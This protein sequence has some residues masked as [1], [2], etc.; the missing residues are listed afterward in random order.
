MT[1]CYRMT[2]QAAADERVKK[3]Y[4]FKAV[5]YGK[6]SVAADEHCAEA[7]K[8]YAISLG[9]IGDFLGV[10]EKIRNGVSF[11]AHIDKAMKINPTDALLHHLLGRFTYEVLGAIAR[12]LSAKVSG[13]IA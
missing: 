7:H 3:E 4:S 5:E 10:A 2:A 1:K 6:R 8:W 11:K 9:S 12:F 13:T